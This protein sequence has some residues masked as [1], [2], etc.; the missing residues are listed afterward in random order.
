MP[1]DEQLRRK[2]ARLQ[3]L[4]TGALGR[5]APAVE[6][7]RGTPAPAGGAP[8]GFRQ[9]VSLVLGPGP[10][11]RGL[12]M[13]HFAR[14]SNRIVPIDE[15]P[16]HSARGNRVAF[17]VRDALARAG[18]P[19]AGPDLGGIARHLIVRTTVDGREAVAMLVVTR[20]DK[21]LRAPVRAVLAGPDAPTGFAVNV[22]DQPGPFMV[23]RE[24]LVVGGRGQVRETRLGPAFLVSPAAFFQT[25]V[26]AAR[27]V[28]DE[29]LAAIPA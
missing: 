28:L 12:V 9:K 29:V 10:G 21:R 16:V 20:N 17:A 2:T 3:A 6:P 18:I 23:G 11:G 27:L 22:H 5:S 7:M 19:G 8:W 4:L 24:T 15:C 1:Y 13:G 25:N 14:S 26:E